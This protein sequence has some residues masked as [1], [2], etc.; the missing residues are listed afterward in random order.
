MSVP[1][2]EQAARL[3]ERLASHKAGVIAFSRTGDPGTGEYEDAVI[4]A[5]FGEMPLELRDQ[6]VA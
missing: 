5:A 3:A 4:I 2:E 6:A 1:S